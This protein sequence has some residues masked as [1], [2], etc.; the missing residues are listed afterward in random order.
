MQI[1]TTFRDMTPSPALEA[2]AQR[3]FARLQRVAPRM[4][5]C[6]VTVEQPHRHQQHGSA[7]Q[8]NVVLVIPG[9]K[10]AVTH[11]SHEDAHIALADAFRAARRQLLDHADQQQGFVRVAAGTARAS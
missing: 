6:D 9:A 10:L 11:Q 1:T 2:A 7:F 4:V 5:A 3:W 8:I